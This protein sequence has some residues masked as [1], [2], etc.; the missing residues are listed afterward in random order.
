MLQQQDIKRIESLLVGFHD[1]FAC[2]GFDNGVNEAFTVKLT[3]MDNSPAYSQSLPT[4]NNLKEDILVELASLHVG[5]LHHNDRAVIINP[6]SRVDQSLPSN[7]TARVRI[8]DSAIFSFF[9]YL[10]FHL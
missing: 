10:F 3:P 4:P 8:C 6:L 1:I 5:A 2:H 9:V 7:R